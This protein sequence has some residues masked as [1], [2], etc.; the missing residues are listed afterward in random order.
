MSTGAI[1]AVVGINSILKIVLKG[2]VAFE[3]VR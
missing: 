1:G 2:L 3:Q